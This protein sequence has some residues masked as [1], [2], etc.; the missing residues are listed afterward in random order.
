[1]KTVYIVGPV[2]GF[3]AFLGYFFYWSGPLPRYRASPQEEANVAFAVLQLWCDGRVPDDLTIAPVLSIVENGPQLRSRLLLENPGLETNLVDDLLE[4]SVREAPTWPELQSLVAAA[5]KPA[6]PIRQDA[7][8]E[9]ASR[10]T[11]RFAEFLMV[12]YFDESRFQFT[13]VGFSKS[14][15]AALVLTSFRAKG[16]GMGR[17]WYLKRSSGVWKVQPFRGAVLWHEG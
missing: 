11:D 6:G 12:R 1:M 17:V 14:G 5:A 7:K 8:A 15:D 10:A 16:G 9:I 4:K 13:R 3:T 2:V